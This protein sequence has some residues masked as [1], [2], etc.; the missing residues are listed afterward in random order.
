VTAPKVYPKT[1]T[2]CQGPYRGTKIS[3]YCDP[4]YAQVH[5]EKF[6]RPGSVVQDVEK[7]CA[8]CA[9]TYLGPPRSK[10]C[11]E[12]TADRMRA[13]NRERKALAW[14][15][16]KAKRFD[17]IRPKLPPPCSRC[18]YCHE[19]EAYPS[20]MVCLAEAFMRCQPWNLGAK[21]LKEKE[22]V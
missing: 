10:F 6:R 7:V 21:P 15:A 20:G 2:K 14:E 3:K 4:C 8:Q 9:I 5:R 19:T 16:L 22:N 11:I 12:C 17:A 13:Y 18:H 1:C